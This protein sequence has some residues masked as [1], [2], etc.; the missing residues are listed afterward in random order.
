[1]AYS[2]VKDPASVLDYPMNWGDPT[3][4]WLEDGDQLTAATVVCADDDLTVDDVTFTAGGLVTAWISGGTTGT[5]YTVVYEV[6]T[7]GGRVDQ[8][9]LIIKCKER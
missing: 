6:T 4:S 1:M 3:D 5:N 9:T 2:K 7:A 8:R